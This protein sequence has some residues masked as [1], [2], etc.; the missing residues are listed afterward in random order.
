MVTNRGKKVSRIIFFEAVFIS[1]CE[2]NYYTKVLCLHSRAVVS[3][4]MHSFVKK[5]AFSNYWCGRNEKV[6]L[7]AI[8]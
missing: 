7:A 5:S 6:H 2:F 8:F 4:M 1:I 3:P